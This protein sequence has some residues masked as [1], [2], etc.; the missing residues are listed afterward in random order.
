MV[1][2]MMAKM[3]MRRRGKGMLGW[4]KRRGMSAAIMPMGRNN[5]R[6]GGNADATQIQERCLNVLD[7]SYL[8]SLNIKRIILFR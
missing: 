2:R 1:T 5:A 6:D 4:T 8:D 7:V 3:D